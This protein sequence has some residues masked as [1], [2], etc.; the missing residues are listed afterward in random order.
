MPE[1]TPFV[2]V[3]MPVRNEADFVERAVTSVLNNDYPAEKME[4]IV[5]DGISDDGTRETVGRLSRQDDRVKMLDNPQQIVPTAMNIGLRAA[6]GDV[7]IRVDGHAEIPP[8]FV[9]RSVECLRDH[10]DAWV[11][12]GRIETVADDFIGRAVA[13]AMR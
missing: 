13:S 6:R 2:S 11:V 9:T 4:V 12:G 3:I 1:D 10:P 7:F 8:D 5:V